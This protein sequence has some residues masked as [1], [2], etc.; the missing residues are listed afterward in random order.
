M[1]F[2]PDE[3]IIAG[4][5]HSFQAHVAARHGPLVGLLE[6]D[7]ANE[8]DDRR[9]IGEDACYIGAVLGLAIE[10]LEG[11]CRTNL[12]PVLLWNDM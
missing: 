5:D 4:P 1:A 10:P 9:L 8:A 12:A 11:I 7:C 3:G 6:Q 2:G